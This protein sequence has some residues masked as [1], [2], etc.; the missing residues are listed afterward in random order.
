[1]TLSSVLSEVAILGSVILALLYFGWNGLLFV[2]VLIIGVTY[3]CGALFS[4]KPIDEASVAAARKGALA[5]ALLVCSALLV[6]WLMGS[7]NG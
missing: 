3:A 4:L 7:G 5:V 1:M 6:S 2:P